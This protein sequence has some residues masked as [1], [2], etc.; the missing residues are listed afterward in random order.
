MFNTFNDASRS[1]AED[2]KDEAYEKLEN[3]KVNEVDLRFAKRE[4]VI[5][6]LTDYEEFEHCADM[7]LAIRRHDILGATLAYDTMVVEQAK[8]EAEKE[9]R[10]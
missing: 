6:H 5:K 3:E 9:W 4:A 10:A 1:V 8:R 7:I 2:N